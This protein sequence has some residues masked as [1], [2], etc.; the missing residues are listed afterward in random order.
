MYL[1]FV[2]IDRLT[3]IQAILLNICDENKNILPRVATGR[4]RQ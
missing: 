1:T 4:E 2:I 3:H